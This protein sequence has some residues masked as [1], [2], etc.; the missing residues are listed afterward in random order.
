[1]SVY[2]RILLYW[3]YKNS[4][5]NS[6]K[7]NVSYLKTPRVACVIPAKNVAVKASLLY[8]VGCVL[9]SI[10]FWSKVPN[11]RETTATGPIAMSREL[12]MTA[13]IS[14]GTKLESIKGRP[15]H[16]K[17]TQSYIQIKTQKT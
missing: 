1:M 15:K 5:V 8:S 14:G 12:P 4:N 17:I 13:Y 2:H 9:G 6:Y 16:N 11:K 3:C 10:S 7:T